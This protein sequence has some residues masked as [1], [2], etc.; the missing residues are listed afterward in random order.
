MSRIRGW[1]CS[2]HTSRL[3]F[4]FTQPLLS[5]SIFYT[6][7]HAFAVWSRTFISEN[8]SPRA[9][10]LPRCVSVWIRSSMLF[11]IAY[12]RCVL[13]LYL[14]L[15]FAN[16]LWYCLC[17]AQ[18]L[19]KSNVNNHLMWSVVRHARVVERHCLRASHVYFSHTL[20]VRSCPRTDR[21]RP[22][23]AVSWREGCAPDARLLLF[24][25]CTLRAKLFPA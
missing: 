7:A 24:C 11:H 15:R 9:L 16:S 22:R 4:H 6:R 3:S 19:L 13:T 21:D 23:C 1:S 25:G 2:L 5:Y 14:L 17:R 20:H 18:A 10:T 12:M 8:F